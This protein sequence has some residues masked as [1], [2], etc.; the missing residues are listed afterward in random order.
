MSRGTKTSC[1]GPVV[2]P[3]LPQVTAALI[4]DLEDAARLD[5]GRARLRRHGA[6]VRTGVA[7]TVRGGMARLAL[8]GVPLRLAAPLSGAA[9]VPR[10]AAGMVGPAPP[11]VPVVPLVTTVDGFAL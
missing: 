9:V 3:W 5:G 10:A 11:P 4:Q 2:A 1:R 8:P 7:G 6:G